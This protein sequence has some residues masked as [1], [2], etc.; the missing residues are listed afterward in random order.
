MF[1][2][3]RDELNRKV[4]GWLARDGNVAAG[5]SSVWAEAMGRMLLW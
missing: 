3:H 5:C 4:Y 1:G 2:M